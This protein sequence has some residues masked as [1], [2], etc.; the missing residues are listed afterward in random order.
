MVQ[1]LEGDNAIA[2]YRALMGATNPKDAAPG[3]LRALYAESIDHNA[4]H[5]SDSP[6]NA[7]IEIAFFFGKDELC[8]R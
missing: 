2:A 1:V 7:E 3:T 4:V 8:A 6:E 5:G